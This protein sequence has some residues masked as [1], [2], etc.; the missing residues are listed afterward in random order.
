M[1]FSFVSALITLAFF[2]VS[3]HEVFPISTFFFSFI[4]LKKSAK[5]Y[6]S[7]KALAVSCDYIQKKRRVYRQ[8]FLFQEF[9]Y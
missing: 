9:V 6:F 3:Y 2:Q 8:K 5:I 4:L 1:I 7:K